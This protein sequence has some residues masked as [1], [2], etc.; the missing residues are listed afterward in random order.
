M[1]CSNCGKDI[2]FAGKVCPWCHVDKSADQQQ[3]IL[4][5]ICGMAGGALGWAINGIVLALVGLVVGVVVG[6]VLAKRI[7]S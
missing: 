6:I 2:P 1:R 5:F 7:Q 3:Q 4:A